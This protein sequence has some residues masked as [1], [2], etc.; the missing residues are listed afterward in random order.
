M[1]QWF[2]WRMETKMGGESSPPIEN[3]DENQA[4]LGRNL[5]P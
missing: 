5:Y 1:F 2:R 3:V 4:N